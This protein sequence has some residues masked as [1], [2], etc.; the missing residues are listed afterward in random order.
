V[1]PIF[2]KA[3]ILKTARDRDSVLTGHHLP[4]QPY[5][6]AVIKFTWRIYAVSERLLVF[7]FCLAGWRG[8][9]ERLMF[10]HSSFIGW[11]VGWFNAKFLDS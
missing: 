11:L 2:F 9:R 10:L 8:S 3:A 5:I 4:S 7:S 1:I 6:K